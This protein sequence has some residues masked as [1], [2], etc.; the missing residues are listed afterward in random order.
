MR[1]SCRLCGDHAND[2]LLAP[3]IQ[4]SDH[5]FY[6]PMQTIYALPVIKIVVVVCHFHV[7]YRKNMSFGNKI[8]NDMSAATACKL[9]I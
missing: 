5:K 4:M 6:E 3:K 7:H 2:L 8:T 9:K 1:M